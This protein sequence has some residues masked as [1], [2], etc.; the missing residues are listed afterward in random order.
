[1][2]DARATALFAKLGIICEREPD[3]IAE[4]RKADFYCSGHQPFWCE[5]KTLERLSDSQIVG[6][7]LADLSARARAITLPG[8]G[9]AFIGAAFNHRDAKTV[10]HLA[11]RA[12]TRFQDGDAPDQLV[13]LI[14]SGADRSR[15]VRFAIST[16]DHVKVEFH[17]CVAQTGKY[18]TPSS[19]VLQPDDQGTRLRFSFGQ[20]LELSAEDVIERRDDFVVAIVI[21]PADGPFDVIAAMPT[22]P[23]RRL[24]NPERIREAISDANKQLKNAIQYK[25]APALVLIYQDGLDV[26]DEEIIKSGLYGNLKYQ[27]APGNPEAGRLILDRNG[28]W[29]PGKNRT[30]SAVMYVRNNGPPLVTHN[31][32]AER[33]LRAGMFACKEALVLSNGTFDEVDFSATSPI[34]FADRLARARFRMRQLYRS[35]AARL[36]S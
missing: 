27:F 30:T 36:R 21:D 1:V 16:R 18:G 33:P 26:P 32:W 24:K 14:P 2:T 15:F 3:W 11:R 22:G 8:R 35:R 20:E 6:E 31:Y 10:M 5:V 9:I 17:A 23:A 12:I 19:I 29:N 25:S 34:G 28:A 7:A 13:A 4:G